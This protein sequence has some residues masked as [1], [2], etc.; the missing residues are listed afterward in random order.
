VIAEQAISLEAVS[1]GPE[2][3]TAGD[4]A[5]AVLGVTSK[6]IYLE[7]SDSKILV[8]VDARSP[9]SPL[10][11]RVGDLNP[12]LRACAASHPNEARIEQGAIWLRGEIDIRVGLPRSRLWSP[13]VPQLSGVT[14]DARLLHSIVGLVNRQ[15]STGAASLARDLA[16]AL[17]AGDCP[18]VQTGHDEPVAA[19]IAKQVAG[20]IE[21][22]LR[23]EEQGACECLVTVLGLGPGLTP[24]GDDFLAGA[25]A[26]LRWRAVASPFAT[27]LAKAVTTQAS[28]RTN[29]ISAALLRYAAEGLLYAPAADL[30]NALGAGDEQGAIAATRDLL[31]L[32]ASSGAD[33]LAGIL[34][35]LLIARVLA[36][37]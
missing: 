22:L 2:A 28:K 8:L 11:I 9:D 37:L 17:P 33:T 13:Q 7:T 32:G 24:S 4:G 35:G 19:S 1:L 16:I 29:K 31:D 10:S 25:L 34:A 21:L 12:L 30:G 36:R 18:T 23:R 15:A 20:A 14:V 26:A 6:C 5:C 3:L 27:Q